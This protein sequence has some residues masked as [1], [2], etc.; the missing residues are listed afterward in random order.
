MC[1]ALG[2]EDEATQVLQVKIAYNL[3][4]SRIYSYFCGFWQCISCLL[5]EL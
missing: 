3:M 5:A 1:S 4:Y 2:R